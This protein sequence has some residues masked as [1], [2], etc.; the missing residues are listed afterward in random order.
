MKH[1]PIVRRS[2][3]SQDSLASDFGL[4]FQ[5]IADAFHGLS[6]SSRLESR[7]SKMRA[8]GGEC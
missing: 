4:I 8:C 5:A 3:Q 1:E 7:W 6:S 2:A